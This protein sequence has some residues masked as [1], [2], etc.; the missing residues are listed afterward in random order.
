LRFGMATTAPAPTSNRDTSRPSSVASWASEWLAAVDCSTM[1]AFCWVTWSIWLTAVFTSAS[2]VACSLAEA[3]IS[4]TTALMSATCWAMRPRALPASPT[5]STPLA[6][7]P[8]EAEI[9]PFIS[10]AAS[11]ER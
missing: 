7:W 9:R 3:A 8:E 4:T 10:L 2:P 11:A 1:A 5:R 6:T